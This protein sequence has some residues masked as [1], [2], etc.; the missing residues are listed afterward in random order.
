MF[1]VM[2]VIML[3]I[4]AA[5]FFTISDV[6]RSAPQCRCPSDKKGGDTVTDLLVER[7]KHLHA[8]GKTV[9]CVVPDGVGPDQLFFVPNGGMFEA[10]V[11]RCDSNWLTFTDCVLLRVLMC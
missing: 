11:S 8:S 9:T 1:K 7:P 6:R 5:M 2:W 10:V 3:P 4:N